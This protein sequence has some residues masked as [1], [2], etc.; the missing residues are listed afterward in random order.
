M[1]LL[2]Y[3]GYQQL[4]FHQGKI[5]PD[6]KSWAASER[7]IDKLV[8]VL[9][10]LLVKAFGYELLRFGP[11]LFRAVYIIDGNKTIGCRRYR[12]AAYHIIVV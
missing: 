8:P 9:A 1:E 6:T 12:P 3:H 7:K 2:N 11:V 5:I 10:V 4:H